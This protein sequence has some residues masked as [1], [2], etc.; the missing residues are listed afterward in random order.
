MPH[1]ISPDEPQNADQDVIIAEAA[2]DN[3]DTQITTGTIVGDVEPLNCSSQNSNVEDQDMTMGDAGI[4]GDDVPQSEKDSKLDIKLEV[5][6]EDLFA[7]MESD[8]E[9]PSST[10]QIVKE[11]SSP[12]APSSPVLVDIIIPSIL[13]DFY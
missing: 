12:E 9:F 11:E 8:D 3:E 6:L 13:T 4:E 2:T 1:S 5:K 7:D 10:G